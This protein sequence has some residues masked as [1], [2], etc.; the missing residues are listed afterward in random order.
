MKRSFTWSVIA[1]AV[2]GLLMLANAWR[3][4]E[5]GAVPPPIGEAAGQSERAAPGAEAHGD[6][7]APVPSPR[8]EGYDLEADERLGGHTLERHVGIDEEGLRARLRRERRIG[9]A[10]SYVDR[11]T[12]ERVV[13]AT[14]ARERMRLEQWTAR[15]GNRPN[16]ALDF[17][18]SRGEV[19]GHTLR[20][21]GRRLEPCQD[22]V[23]VLR[24][25]E[26]RHRWF[27]LTS[28]PEIRR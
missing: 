17:Q 8:P 13:A 4:G 10:S 28:Y 3:T 25:D 22:A 6:G 7:E 27:V 11:A 26:G 19:I 12:A 20:R 24:W 9:A 2:V 14:L 23:V 18:G 21:S 5:E 16:L 15:R 1:L